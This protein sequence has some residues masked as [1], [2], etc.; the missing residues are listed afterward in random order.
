MKIS[1]VKIE[2]KRFVV[3]QNIFSSVNVL[4]KNV[5]KCWNSVESC[6]FQV[7]MTK[8]SPLAELN[9]M[10]KICDHPRLLSTMSS[11]TLGLPVE[12]L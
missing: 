9:V 8:R 4:F 5:C 11:E 2:L 3:I 12:E 6:L 7:L 1:S 10:K